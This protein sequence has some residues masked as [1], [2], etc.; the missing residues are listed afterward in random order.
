VKPDEPD[1]PLQIRALGMNGVV[2]ETEHCTDFIEEF[3]LLTSRRVRHIRAQA[4]RLE[5]TDK[6]HRAKLPENPV[7]I[8]LSGQNGKL[9]NG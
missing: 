8:A 2:V 1:D 5:I 9:I 7:N 3:W 4:G 6:R